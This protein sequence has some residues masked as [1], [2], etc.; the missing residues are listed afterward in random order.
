LAERQLTILAKIA[1]E[2]RYA[3]SSLGRLDGVNSLYVHF[4]SCH[5]TGGSVV[6]RAG[7]LLRLRPLNKDC[8]LRL[9]LHRLCAPSL[10][11]PSV[12][13]LQIS[14]VDERR[15][16]AAGTLRGLARGLFFPIFLQG[17]SAGSR[18]ATSRNFGTVTWAEGNR[19]GARPAAPA[20]GSARSPVRLGRPERIVAGAATSPKHG[21]RSAAR[22]S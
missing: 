10:D 12:G 4:Q 8:S 5:H 9:G 1:G 18:P 3:A 15:L 13:D 7:K 6:R 21:T 22:W 2:T 14:L 16:L 19:L 11:V 20:A 17:I